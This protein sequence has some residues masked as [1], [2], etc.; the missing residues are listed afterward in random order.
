MALYSVSIVYNVTTMAVVVYNSIVIDWSVHE[1]MGCQPFSEWNVG[2]L[3][4]MTSF[5]THCGM[6][7][8]STVQVLRVY[9][10]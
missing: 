1:C 6:M 7:S 4:A 3:T 5:A 8:F 10:L 9:V 2:Q